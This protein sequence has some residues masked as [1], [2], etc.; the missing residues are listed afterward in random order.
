MNYQ[1][2]IYK[3]GETIQT[4]SQK[5]GKPVPKLVEEIRAQYKMDEKVGKKA[6][7]ELMTYE[8][9]NRRLRKNLKAGVV[10]SFC[11]LHRDEAIRIGIQNGY[12][13]YTQ[14][15][16]IGKLKKAEQ[17]GIDTEKAMG[18]WRERVVKCL[19]PVVRN[20][21]INLGD[22]EEPKWNLESVYLVKLAIALKAQGRSVCILTHHQETFDLACLN[23]IQAVVVV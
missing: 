12:E 4:I 21:D 22:D 19:K 3:D 5:T 17:K 9:E 16:C 10:D 18:L 13:F 7:S 15:I 8:M 2:A 23:D 6:Y 1:K 20:E 11:M 14:P